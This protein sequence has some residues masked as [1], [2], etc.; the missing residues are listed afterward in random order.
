MNECT[1][2]AQLLKHRNSGTP[3]RVLRPKSC[4]AL[5]STQ[6][7]ATTSFRDKKKVP[8]HVM[9]TPGICHTGIREFVVLDHAAKSWP[10]QANSFKRDILDINPDPHD[11]FS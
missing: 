4:Q 9:F 3:S 5:W 1:A 11:L 7:P 6:F 8:N 2:K 10:T